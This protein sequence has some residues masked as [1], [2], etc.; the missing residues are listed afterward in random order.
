MK[1]SHLLYAFA[2]A[3]LVGGYLYAQ[4]MAQHGQ[5]PTPADLALQ[6]T[7]ACSYPVGGWT[8]IDCSNAAAAQSAQLTSWA[9]YAIQCGDD[10]YIAWGD[11]ATD[12]ADTS[13]G[14]VPSGAWVDFFT[15]STVRYVSCRNKNVDSDCRYIQC[16]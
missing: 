12:E 13:D 4:P 7:R 2:A 8:I 14:W 9:R 6:A 16:K 15:T 1:L 3:V 11:E 5:A 10:S